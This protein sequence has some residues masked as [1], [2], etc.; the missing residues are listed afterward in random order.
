M[1]TLNRTAVTAL[2]MAVLVETMFVIHPNL[3]TSLQYLWKHRS[4]SGNGYCNIENPAVTNQHQP[5]YL[6][7]YSTVYAIAYASHSPT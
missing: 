2:S 6:R 4:T 5:C 1:E 3:W 7:K